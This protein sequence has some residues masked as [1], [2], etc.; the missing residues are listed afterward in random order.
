MNTDLIVKY[1]DKNW[2]LATMKAICKRSISNMYVSLFFLSI[3]TV[4]FMAIFR[5]LPRYH[6]FTSGIFLFGPPCIYSD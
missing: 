3:D 4:N 5:I 2:K 6:K 1:P